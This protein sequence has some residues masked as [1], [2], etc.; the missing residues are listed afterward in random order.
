MWPWSTPFIGIDRGNLVDNGFFPYVYV[1]HSSLIC[2]T[3][4][5]FFNL[6]NQDRLGW[7]THGFSP[8]T[9][10]NLISCPM[11]GQPFYHMPSHYMKWSDALAGNSH[12]DGPQL[13]LFIWK[14]IW[15]RTMRRPVFLKD[16]FLENQGKV[17]S[18]MPKWFAVWRIDLQPHPSMPQFT[19]W[20]MSGWPSDFPAMEP[21]NY[22]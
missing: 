21:E 9:H 7:V 1:Y 4:H 3:R 2:Q 5:H 11:V 19:D 18:N 17:W 10:P 16:H 15:Y 14:I 13:C 8:S 20:V 12:H 6:E 22:N